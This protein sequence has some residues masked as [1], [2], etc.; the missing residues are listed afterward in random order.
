MKNT[1]LFFLLFLAI[2]VHAQYYYKDIIGTKETNSLLKI[3]TGNNVRSVSLKSF[4][5]E[6][7]VPDTVYDND[8]TRKNYECDE[9]GFGDGANEFHRT[10]I[11]PR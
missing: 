1:V 5:A 7:S 4:E 10:F 11:C 3:Y 2:S 9:P 6:I 8:E